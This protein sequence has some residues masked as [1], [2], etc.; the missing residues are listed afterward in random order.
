MAAVNLN[1]QF[2]MVDIGDGGRQSDSG[3]FAASNTGRALD[4]GLLNKPQPRRLYGDTKLF[5]FVLV[6]DEAFL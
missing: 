4:D 2:T 6:S 5:L 1:Y 3:V